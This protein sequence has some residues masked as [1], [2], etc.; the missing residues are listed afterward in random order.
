MDRALARSKIS[1][2]G[3]LLPFEKSPS[4]AILTSIIRQLWG[5][6]GGGKALQPLAEAGDSTVL[7]ESHNGQ[8]GKEGRKV[9][10]G[11][12]IKEGGLEIHA[13]RIMMVTRPDTPL[14]APQ[15]SPRREDEVLEGGT[16]KEG[17]LEKHTAGIMTVTQP[18]TPLCNPPVSLRREEEIP[19]LGDNR[20]PAWTIL[21]QSSDD[22]LITSLASEDTVRWHNVKC[23][24]WDKVDQ[25]LEMERSPPVQFNPGPPFA[26]GDIVFCDAEECGSLT[27]GL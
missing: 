6:D 25:E 19:D 5:D 7:V 9:L 1:A 17:G 21:A 15:V 2:R 10:E 13:A 16:I 20:L 24:E 14:G 11:G 23:P 3:L 18:D 4:L 27:R 12:T 8:G 22:N 26:I